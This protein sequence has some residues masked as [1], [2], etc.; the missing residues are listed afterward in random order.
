MNKIMVTLSVALFLI[1]I[2]S[3]ASAVTIENTGSSL[4]DTQLTNFTQQVNSKFDSINTKLDLYAKKG[5]IESMLV[6]Q[7][8]KQQEINNA[9]LSSMLLNACF[10]ILATLGLGF[11]TYFYFKSKNRI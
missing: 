5:D 1:I 7:L 9:L 4:S 8:K 11:G 2:S 6:A 10:M 3:F